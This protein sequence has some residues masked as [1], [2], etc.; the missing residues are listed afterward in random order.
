[1]QV[2]LEIIARKA[3]LLLFRRLLVLLSYFIPAHDQKAGAVERV[4]DRGLIQGI[5][6]TL[7]PFF[8]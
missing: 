6:L 8:Y 7:L 4:S 2:L 5:K 1:M 3:R